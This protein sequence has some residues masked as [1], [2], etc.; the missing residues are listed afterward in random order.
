M[1]EIDVCPQVIAMCIAAKGSR[2]AIFLLVVEFSPCVGS[3]E[4]GRYAILVG[5]RISMLARLV[6]FGGF[7]LRHQDSLSLSFALDINSGCG[8]A[9][10]KYC[11]YP[12]PE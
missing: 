12:L 2:L 3:P 10:V 4:C 8:V 6:I 7:I 11:G 9:D 5:G 1:I